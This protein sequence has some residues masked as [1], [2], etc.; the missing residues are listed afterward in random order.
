MHVRCRCGGGIVISACLLVSGSRRTEAFSTLYSRCK[1]GALRAGRSWEQAVPLD[2][3][4]EDVCLVPPG[5]EEI[6]DAQKA[7]FAETALFDRS[8]QLFPLASTT[9]AFVSYES[10]AKWA[11]MGIDFFGQRQS[12]T[13][14][15]GN[16]YEIAILAPTI[17][18]VVM[19]SVSIALGTLAAATVSSLRLRQLD[20]RERLN[21]ELGEIELLRTTIVAL[22]D[23]DFAP[24]EN[25]KITAY[26]TLL[27][28]DYV[29]RVAFECRPNAA[30]SRVCDTELNALY[31]L[32][33]DIKDEERRSN[34]ASAS[35]LTLVNSLVALR[36]GR[37]TL[38][39]SSYPPTQFFVLAFGSLSIVVAF[40]L[41]SD[42]EVLRFLDAIQLRLLFS[43]LVGVFSGLAAVVI[44]LA[45][46]TRGTFR[47]T[48]VVAQFFALRDLLTYDLCCLDGSDLPSRWP[49][50][51]SFAIKKS[52]V[53]QPSAYVQSPLE[54]TLLRNNATNPPGL[55]LRG[56]FG[57]RNDK[58]ADTL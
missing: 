54:P 41:E 52:V 13:S 48:T 51:A 38:L 16:V 30:V 7:M 1:G 3:K 47:I 11:R 18:G 40:L 19:P 24:S 35:A 28:R 20:V 25:K 43:I 32:F 33:L 46:I 53:R 9:L 44:D 15:D 58:N 4:E 12:W 57:L 14:V 23:N 22:D 6:L 55:A 56:S 29:S 49:Y 50:D 42:Q 10:V 26:A 5:D 27:L 39:A 36:A 8:L 31:R 17:N 21:R 37:L 45:D 2:C 34:P